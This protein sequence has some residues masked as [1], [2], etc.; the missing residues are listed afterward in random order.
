ML[1]PAVSQAANDVTSTIP[2]SATIPPVLSGSEWPANAGTA[3]ST[4]LASASAWA[5]DGVVPSAPALRPELASAPGFT[6]DADGNAPAAAPGAATPNG[7]T[8]PGVTTLPAHT[9]V[10]SAV[11]IDDSDCW[12]CVFRSAGRAS[13]PAG[14]LLCPSPTT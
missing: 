12:A 4:S 6:A 9:P 1:P 5:A 11:P 8:P 3:A 2:S 10:T 7:V 14:S 13:I